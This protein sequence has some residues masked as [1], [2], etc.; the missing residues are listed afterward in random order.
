MLDRELLESQLAEFPLF[1]YGF[2]APTELDFTERVRGQCG[3]LPGQM[4]CLCRLPDDRHHHR[5]LGHCKRGRSVGYQRRPRN[6]YH[7]GGGADAPAGDRALHTVHR[8]LRHLRKMRLFG[9]SALPV[10]GKNASLR[11]ESRH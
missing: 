4:S 9:R 5:G 11:G 7:R 3:D 10:P 8:G 1:T 2:I 6:H